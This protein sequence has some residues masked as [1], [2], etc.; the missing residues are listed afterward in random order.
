MSRKRYNRAEKE[1]VEAKIDL[2]EKSSMKESLTEH[3][4]AVIQ[5]NEARKA[6]RLFKLMEELGIEAN[7]CPIVL[8]D[9]PPMLSSFPSIN[10][11]HRSTT[12]PLPQQANHVS[13]NQ[14]QDATVDSSNV[15]ET[16][17]ENGLHS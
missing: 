16:C 3:L 2:A 8:P 4:Y 7:K 6:H 10:T 5:C 14:V 11:F 12:A 9:L 15:V 13:L 1:F 17:A